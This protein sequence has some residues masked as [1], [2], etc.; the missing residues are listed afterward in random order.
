MIADSRG[1]KYWN[2]LFG[3]I[4]ASGSALETD[5][6]TDARNES[7]LDT[8]FNETWRRKALLADS[9]IKTIIQNSTTANA[10][11]EGYEGAGY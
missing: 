9:G 7:G 1:L 5:I 8:L 10:L 11:M 3:G 6:G 2:V 4:I